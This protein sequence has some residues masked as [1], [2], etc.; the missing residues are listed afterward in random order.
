MRCGSLCV[1]RP[2]MRSAVC[3]EDRRNDRRQPRAEKTPQRLNTPER[4]EHP[5]RT[6]RANLQCRQEIGVSMYY[7]LCVYGAC[8]SLRCLVRSIRTAVLVCVSSNASSRCSRSMQTVASHARTHQQ[9]YDG[10]ERRGEHIRLRTRV[11]RQEGGARCGTLSRREVE[12][13]DTQDG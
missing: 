12:A 3:R 9:R 7:L 11:C 2:G 1:C 6:D 5:Q 13:I 8:P 10:H 4:R